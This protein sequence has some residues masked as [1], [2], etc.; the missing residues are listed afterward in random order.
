MDVKSPEHL[1]RL[2]NQPE[3]KVAVLRFVASEDSEFVR[4]ERS[5][6]NT[7]YWPL[8]EALDKRIIEAKDLSGVAET[9]EVYN[10][11]CW[12]LAVSLA[13]T[14]GSP[15]AVALA[16]ADGESIDKLVLLLKSVCH[17]YWYGSYFWK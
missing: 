9:V 7:D 14:Q 4:F 13:P 5:A 1:E 2:R 11:S 8:V 10:R 15:Y 17:D 3:F 12:L 6:K 16:A